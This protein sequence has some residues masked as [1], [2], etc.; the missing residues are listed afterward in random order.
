MIDSAFSSLSVVRSQLSVV[1]C[2]AFG[3]SPAAAACQRM[4]SALSETSVPLPMNLLIFRLSLVC[5][6]V[7]A[8]VSLAQEGQRDLSTFPARPNL[9]QNGSFEELTGIIPPGPQA[10]YTFS[11]G[12]TFIHAWRVIANYG[13]GGIDF[14]PKDTLLRNWATDGFYGVDLF[15]S[16]FASANGEYEITGAG[17]IAQDGIVLRKGVYQLEFDLAN[18]DGPGQFVVSVVDSRGQ[19]LARQL[20]LPSPQIYDI[21]FQFFTQ[22]VIFKV[23]KAVTVTVSFVAEGTNMGGNKSAGPVIDNVRLER[24]LR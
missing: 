4:V 14:M 12:D 11:E 24:R 23:K 5:T 21:P 10:F 20:F 9:I 1:C 17:G 16:G 6:A 19:V 22:Q 7:L 8:Q 15:A 13:G 3:R 2:G 18:G